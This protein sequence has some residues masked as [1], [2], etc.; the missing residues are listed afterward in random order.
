MK[1]IPFLLLAGAALLSACHSVA[2]TSN[3]YTQFRVTN[4]RGE[5][6]ADWVV[7]G[8]YRRVGSGYD[9]KA[10]ERKSGPPLS[11]TTRYPNGWRTFIDGPHII[12]WSCGKPHW[13]YKLDGY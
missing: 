7:E 11:Q 8:T 9:I 10:V 4:Q 1:F 3:R 6:I 12:R 2:V 13:L 5:L